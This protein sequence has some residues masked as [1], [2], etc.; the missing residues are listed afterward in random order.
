MGLGAALVTVSPN[1]TIKSSDANS[2]WQALNNAATPAFTSVTLNLPPILAAGHQETGKVGVMF[3]NATTSHSVGYGV[4]FKTVL[5]NTPSSITLTLTGGEANVAATHADQIDKY[6]FRFYVDL[7]ANGDGSW[8]G[9]Y[10][11]VGNCLLSVDAAARTFDHH[12]DAC[13]RVSLDVP[14]RALVIRDP[15]A[16]RYVGWRL[17]AVA[18]WRGLLARLGRDLGWGLSLG[19]PAP[20]I[21][22]SYALS[23][24]CPGCGAREFF[25]TALT[26]ADERDQT[27]M[28][29]PHSTYRV[30]YGE[31]AQRVRALIRALG[32]PLIEE[33]PERPAPAPERAA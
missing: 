16:R 5:T 2:N 22:G 13:R 33:A 24:I 4:N 28:A 17:R 19:V 20:L 18:V 29:N 23:Y 15:R 7:S 25:N 10:T 3:A 1:T 8:N 30:S 32:L 26:P 21:P 6:G 9:Q 12:C 31:Q 14:F 11:T 27:V